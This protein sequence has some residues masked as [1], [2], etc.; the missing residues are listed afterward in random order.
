MEIKIN[1]NW[2]IS[3]RSLNVELLRATKKKDGEKKIGEKEPCESGWWIVGYFQKI[4][5]ALDRLFDENVYE[6]EAT[7]LEAFKAEIEKLR[8]E[9]VSAFK[10]KETEGENNQNGTNR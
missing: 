2:K 8:E 6:S 3:S 4:E 5:Y 9:V 7:S 1:K 10:E